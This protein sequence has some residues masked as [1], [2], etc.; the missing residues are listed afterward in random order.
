MISFMIYIIT[1]HKMKTYIVEKF[2]R[3][4]S[5]LLKLEANIHDQI[6]MKYSVFLVE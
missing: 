3:I 1:F 2:A 5:L 6:R 4:S